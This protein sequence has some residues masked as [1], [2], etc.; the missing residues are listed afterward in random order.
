[1]QKFK[2]RFLQKQTKRFKFLFV[3]V[4]CSMSSL[5]SAQTVSGVI[6]D[7]DGSPLPGVSVV[8]KG[9][10]NG[11]SS[12]FD[13]NYEI[14][15]ADNATLVFSSIG[16][17]AQEVAVEGRTVVNVSLD[18]D[19]ES[20]DE[21]V[22][23]GYGSQ[24]K[25]NLSG[26]VATVD[27]EA[28]ENIP[29]VS[30]DQLIQGRAAGVYVTSNSGQPGSSVSV[31]IRGVNTITGSSEP[32][33]IIDGVPVSGESGGGSDLSPLA[34][35][36]PSDIETVNILKDASATAIYGSRGSNG[37]VIITTKRGKTGKGA[38]TYDSFIA[39]QVPT[40][41]IEVLDLPGYARL[42]NEMSNVYGTNPQIEFQQPDLLG[43]GTNWQ[44]EIFSEALMQNH[45]ISFSGGQ[46][47]TNYYVSASY[48][49]QDG[50]VIGS[51]FDRT[52]I[53]ANVNSK[54]NDWITAGISMTASRT[55]ERLTLNGQNNGII[56][57]SLA[58][59][60]ATAVY[61]P[62]GSFAGPETADEIAN[63][64][65]NPIAEALSISNKLRRN[66]LLGNIYA[67]FKITDW[68][69]FR[70]EFGGDFGNNLQSNFR[71]YFTYGALDGG[72][73][74]LTETRRNNDFWVI[75]N[76]LTFHN[77]FND[78][79]DL[80]VLLGQ[81]AQE[82]SYGGIT[83]QDGDF[84][85]NDVPI[86][87]TGNAN[88]ITSQYK[89]SSAISSYFSRAIYTFDNKYNVTASIRADGSS[90][91]AE[92][93]KWGYFPSISAAWS[94]SKEGFME[95]VEA[96]Q[97]IKIYGGYGEVGNQN[98]PGY[99]Y[100]SKL[101]TVN[102]Q[103]GTGFLIDNFANPD[104]VWESSTQV[105]VGVDMSFFD[106]RLSTTI[107]VYNKVSKD[108]LYQLAVTDFI[109][110]GSSPGAITAPW[111]NLGEMVNKGVDLTVSYNTIG[112]GDFTWNSTLTF[113]HYKNEV[114]ELLDDL[115]INT[116]VFIADN[117]E[118]VTLTEVGKPLGLFYGYKVEGLFRTMSDIEGAPIQF[119]RPFQEG[120]AGT[121]WLG[122]IKYV[123]VNGDGVIDANDRT[124]IGN[125]HPDFTFGWQNSFNY[126]NWDLSIFMQGSYGNDIINL[127]GRDLTT[128]S[129]LY[130]NQLPSVLDAWSISNP[131]GQSPRIAADDSQ[132]KNISDRYIEDGSYLRIQNLMLGY[133]LPS[134]V[135]E[136]IG[137][138]RMK[139][140]GSIQNL[141]TFTNYSGYDPEVGS[142]NQNTLLMGVD[143]GRYPSPRTFTMGINLEF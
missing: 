105:N 64:I 66:R 116:S 62:D 110:G 126:K 55:N 104:L 127:I 51:A 133:N 96:V 4:F 21:V 50:T 134:G 32:L 37:V 59:N 83:A 123:D 13:G 121:N 99:A 3:L 124:E 19:L 120:T 48:L 54:I 34:A 86:L 109:V 44:Q 93:N 135:L 12:D 67:Q 29:Q 45:Q 139:L 137:M 140:Y 43:P 17:E 39:V 10:T 130:R 72:V 40:N 14:T 108:F 91:F 79:H 57:L 102:T 61:N 118:N 1:M 31:R 70:T 52:T 26:S 38:F 122:D 7:G 65:R 81:E 76:L 107:E 77:T 88:D 128:A 114:T 132:N 143:Y 18:D 92:G 23:I 94:I 2:F 141:Y 75:K 129:L 78:K 82:S 8:E 20:L 100:G 15:V 28:L 103:L 22:I 5:I 80:T 142:L 41:M 119:G 97:G 115:K 6:T 16:F 63:G 24:L 35:I 106:R 95:N 42:Q 53:R 9:T 90:N 46:D 58:N 36:N 11:V 112:S 125:P 131:N 136:K 71:P 101:R 113:S 60:P 74:Q 138:N 30:I 73:N 89:G 69:D 85:S 47:G 84:V 33:Y 87:G 27:T 111:V 49:D 56:G 68:L 98:I 25:E 117:N